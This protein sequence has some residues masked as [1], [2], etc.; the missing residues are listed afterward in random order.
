MRRLPASVFFA[1]CALVPMTAGAQENTGATAAEAAAAVVT[2]LSADD[3]LNIREA[4][5]ALGRT[6]GR[7]PNGSLVR[8][9]RCEIV[10]KYEW[11]RI[12]LVDGEEL[13]GWAPAR[14]LEILDIAVPETAVEAAAETVVDGP[15]AIP[16][17]SPAPREAV[18]APGEEERGKAARVSTDAE[19]PA[20][21]PGLE[22]RFATGSSVPIDEVRRP[23]AGAN[24]LE[25]EDDLPPGAGG[26]EPQDD[27]EEGRFDPATPRPTP[28]PA[29]DGEPAEPGTEPVSA[30]VDAAQPVGPVAEDRPDA[31]AAHTEAGGS[32][33]CARYIG[34]PM[35][36][37]TLRVAPKGEGAADLT[38]L[39]PD[40]GTRLIEFREG[41]P[42]GSNSNET[43][44]HTREGSL[45]MIRI[46]AAERFEILDALALGR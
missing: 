44:R 24:L 34:Q 8:R 18:T 37:C 43:L 31:G 33:P 19:V 21:P 28:R 15:A 22:A 4:P 26:G 35:T 30:G 11:C 10:D 9:Q 12:E 27:P 38:I 23:P 40:G 25:E 6:L 46:G 29:S 13:S 36:R 45:N 32:I 2:G 14:Y 17:P 39:W 41:A 3:L 7:L 20:L 1:F 16:D 42:V 5:S